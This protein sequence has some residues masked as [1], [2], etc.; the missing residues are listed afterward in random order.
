MGAEVTQLTLIRIAEALVL[1]IISLV[2]FLLYG[3]LFIANAL[4]RAYSKYRIWLLVYP[5][6]IFVDPF[7]SFTLPF[8]LILV[9]AVL[10]VSSLTFLRGIRYSSFESLEPQ[11]TKSM[12]QEVLE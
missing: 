1:V 11:W 6:L 5:V 2:V 12:I 4:E 3:P 10:T 7:L 9:L 8:V